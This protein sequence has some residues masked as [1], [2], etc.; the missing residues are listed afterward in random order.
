MVVLNKT[1]SLRP[2]GGGGPQAGFR[3]RYGPFHDCD[4]GWRCPEK[5]GPGLVDMANTLT[6]SRLENAQRPDTNIPALVMVY[7]VNNDLGF[8]YD[9]AF[10]RNLGFITDFEQLALRAK[11]VAIA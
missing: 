9:L 2:P 3:K 11:R 4:D 5:S 1:L 8:P 10:D 6:K 7:C